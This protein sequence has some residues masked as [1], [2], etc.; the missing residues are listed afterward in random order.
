[1]SGAAIDEKIDKKAE[2]A[3]AQLV[4]V[5]DEPGEDATPGVLR[6]VTIDRPDALNA[7]DPATMAALNEAFADS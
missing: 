4:R 2:G 1:M 3:P 6:V 7:I 5:L